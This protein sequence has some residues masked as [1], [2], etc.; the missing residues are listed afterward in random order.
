MRPNKWITIQTDA[1]SS[2]WG[3][4]LTRENQEKVFA[5]GEWKDNNL[6]SSNQREVTAVLKALLEFR[7]ELT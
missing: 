4:T 1:S 7:Q 3:A 5:H 2:G 6:K